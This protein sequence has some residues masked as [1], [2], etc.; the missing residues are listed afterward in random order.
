MGLSVTMG[1]LMGVRGLCSILGG[2]VGD[3]VLEEAGGNWGRWVPWRE[4]EVSLGG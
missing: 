3:A 1:V 4:L 2:L